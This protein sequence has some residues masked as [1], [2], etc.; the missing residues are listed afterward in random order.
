MAPQVA[1]LLLEHAFIVTFDADGTVIADGAIAINDGA[2]IDLGPVDQLRARVNASA[3]RDLGGQIVIPGLVDAHLHTAQTMMRGL[4]TALS[5]KGDLRVP[6]WVEYLVPFESNLSEDDVELSGLL[7]Y[8]TMLETGTTTF[9]EAGGPYPLSMAKAAWTTGIRGAVSQSTMDGGNRIPGSMQMSAD[10][11]LQANINVVEALPHA[12]DGSIRVTGGMSLRQII[13]CSTGLVKDI[14]REAQDRGVK[15][16]THLVE[17][18]YEI[19]YAL[20]NFGHRPVEYLQ[21]IGVFDHTLHGAHSVLVG[22][23]DITAY[24][25]HGVSACHCAKGNFGIGP[26]PAIRMRRRGVD[27]GLGT[28]GV[29]MLGTLDLFRVAMIARVGQQLVEGVGRHNRN[30]IDPREPLEMAIVGGAASMGLGEVIG[31]L[32]T[33]KRAD[34]VVISMDGPDA[35]GY[36]SEEAFLYECAAGQD[37]TEVYVEGRQVVADG[38]C[39]AVDTAEIRARARARARELGALLA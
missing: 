35:A 16:H 3:K 21:S 20:E 38:H 2:I 9:F 33:G 8:S 36:D 37:V 30:E 32:E 15:V 17:G 14:H 26:A 24:A 4:L 7:A 27:I 6:T 18:T 11:A 12:D 13:A 10:Q 28:D 34:L 19:D 1:D 39:T 25:R 22:D 29:A 23:A 31:S 5:R